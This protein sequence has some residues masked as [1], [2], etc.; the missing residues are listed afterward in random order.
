MIIGRDLLVELGIIIDFKKKT[1]S[2]EE[3]MINMPTSSKKLRKT[4]KYELVILENEPESTISLTKCAIKIMD[5]EYE[6]ADLPKVV[7]SCEYLSM[8]EKISY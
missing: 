2:W 8:T 5:V 7:A 4:P 3:A 6:A 1:M